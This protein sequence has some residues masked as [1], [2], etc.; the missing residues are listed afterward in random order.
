[1]CSYCGC[2]AITVIADLTHDHEDVVNALGEVARA[3][4][5][6]DAEAASARAQALAVLLAPHTRD[7]EVGLFAEL[8]REPELADHVRSLVGEHAEIDALVARVAGRDLSAAAPLELLLRRHI[9]KEENGVFPASV[10][11]LDGPRWDSVVAATA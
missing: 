9:E 10:I 6:G 1:M 3:A 4:A 2:R 5:R 8:A 11:A 7:E